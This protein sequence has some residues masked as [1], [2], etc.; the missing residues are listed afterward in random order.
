LNG[1]GAAALRDVIVNGRTGQMPGQEALL[2]A[3]RVHVLAAFV[4][5]LAEGD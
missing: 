2:G 1:S 5:S 4:L 3:D